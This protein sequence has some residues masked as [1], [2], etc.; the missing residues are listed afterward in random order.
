MRCINMSRQYDLAP[1][2]DADLR[3]GPLPFTGCFES[4]QQLR[5]VARLGN[6]TTLTRK[7][8]EL[9]EEIIYL[10]E[11]LVPDSRSKRGEKAF[12]DAVSQ[13]GTVGGLGLVGAVE[14]A[15]SCLYSG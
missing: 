13:S 11:V 10:V 2:P 1:P 15:E 5:L 6:S 7:S 8:L 4:I 12:L 14:L 3:I 9:G